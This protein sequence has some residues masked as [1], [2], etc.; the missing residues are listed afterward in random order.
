MSSRERISVYNWVTVR[1]YRIISTGMYCMFI[2]DLCYYKYW[3]VLYVYHGSL[4]YGAKQG[5]V[6]PG[7]CEVNVYI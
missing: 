2:M 3:Y 5:T 4:L 7:Y 1:Q 6:H